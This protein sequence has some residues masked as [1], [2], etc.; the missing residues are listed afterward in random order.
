[1]VIAAEPGLH[2]ASP[3]GAERPLTCPRGLLGSEAGL[4][5]AVTQ[6][7]VSRRWGRKG[8][9]IA[10][11]GL[12]HGRVPGLQEMP[13]IAARGAGRMKETGG[14]WPGGGPEQVEGGKEKG[15]GLIAT[16]LH[17]E[18]HTKESLRY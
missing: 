6:C 12:S 5:G 10:E 7:R 11:A 3:A 2:L 14:I 13:R 9:W 8:P 4:P 17:R 1:M 15:K 18:A 16:L